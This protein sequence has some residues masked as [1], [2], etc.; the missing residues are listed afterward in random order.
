MIRTILV[1]FCVELRDITI[2]FIPPTPC[3]AHLWLSLDAPDG[4][5][6]SMKRRFSSIP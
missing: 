2:I 6:R 5:V 1:I 3:L 4:F